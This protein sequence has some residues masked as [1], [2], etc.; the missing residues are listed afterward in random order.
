[1]VDAVGTP[2]F[3]VACLYGLLEPSLA[4][5]LDLDSLLYS[6]CVLWTASCEGTQDKDIGL[7]ETDW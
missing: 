2:R 7:Y 5:H 3:E 6:Y 4:V 1:M